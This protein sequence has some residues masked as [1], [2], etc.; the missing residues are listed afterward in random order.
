MSQEGHGV[1]TLPI[2]ES[3]ISEPV[4]S[5]IQSDRTYE[6]NFTSVGAWFGCEPAPRKLTCLRPTQRN[7]LK[8][9]IPT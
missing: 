1:G 3:G 2:W 6:A 9:T 7:P 8:L 4:L 5:W